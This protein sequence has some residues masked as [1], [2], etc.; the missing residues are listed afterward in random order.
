MYF[1]TII[2]RGTTG[3]IWTMAKAF[4][5]LQP[6]RIR[7]SWAVFLFIALS[8]S[9]AG[10][11]QSA[12]D[13]YWGI[14]T[15][16]ETDPIADKVQTLG[17][18][19]IRMTIY[20]NQV[21]RER[22]N[23][24][25]DTPDLQIRNAADRNLNVFVTIHGTPS[26]ANGGKSFE[27]PPD[28]AETW[29]D[30]VA[31]VVRRYR[32]YPE[33]RAIGLW[34]EPNV[35][36]FWQGTAD[37][38]IT[39]ILIPGAK[40]IKNLWPSL[41]VVGPELSDHWTEN[42]REWHIARFLNSG[43]PIDIVSQHVYT[44]LFDGKLPH[45]LDKWVKPFR[46]DRPVW[47]TEIGQDVCHKYVKGEWMQDSYYKYML[48]VQYARRKWV[49][50]IFPYRFWDPAG[51]CKEGNGYGIVYGDELR[52]RKAYSTIKKFIEEHQDFEKRELK[53]PKSNTR[54]GG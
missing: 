28:T 15:G 48:D 3:C 49:M 36:K 9:S 12:P 20:W 41:L 1:H 26:W 13:S 35:P 47:I 53:P 38:Y 18:T 16:L 14:N 33:V 52:E 19:W 21:E 5:Y 2:G 29:T 27:Y 17:V 8:C 40:V 22:G 32:S 42:S 4:V 24:V 50:K 6:M 23:F 44:E 10:H 30:F 31:A 46:G 39:R 7:R 51:N 45:F 54:R 43:A 37:E 25:W 11:S 34:N